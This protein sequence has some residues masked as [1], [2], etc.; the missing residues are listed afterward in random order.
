M[1]V[2]CCTAVIVFHLPKLPYGLS[3]IEY[4]IECNP[5]HVLPLEGPP[6][7]KLVSLRSTST[8]TRSTRSS[9]PHSLKALAS[10][11][12]SRW[13]VSLVLDR[14]VPRALIIEMARGGTWGM[15]TRPG[16]TEMQSRKCMFTLQRITKILHNGSESG[17]ECA[18]DLVMYRYMRRT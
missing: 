5:V 6:V 12:Y 14:P 13:S 3:C 8:L 16:K 10:L 7:D 4:T 2:P 15:A 9:L 11:L 17:S 1:Y 18:R